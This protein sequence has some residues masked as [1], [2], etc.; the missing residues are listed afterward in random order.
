MEEK[1]IKAQWLEHITLNKNQQKAL[2]QIIKTELESD[3]LL[4]CEKMLI[5]AAQAQQVYGSEQL[6]PNQKKAKEN[7]QSLESSLNRAIKA[8]QEMTDFE[9]EILK[10][11][12]FWANDSDKSFTHM[13]DGKDP[14]LTDPINKLLK[15]TTHRLETMSPASKSKQ[16]YSRSL[17]ELA[18][19]FNELFPKHTPS[20][21]PESL[22]SQ[23]VVFWFE[24]YLDHPIANPRRHIEKILPE[25]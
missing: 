25:H 14:I 16:K 17:A 21:E 2:A 6:N 24:N 7:L 18:N 1:N 13:T 19:Q 22:F 5:S 15:G 20:P 12:C 23:L 9:Q 4:K 11:S 10:Q 3:L 8:C